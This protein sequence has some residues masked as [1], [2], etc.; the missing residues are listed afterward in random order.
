MLNKSPSPS[1]QTNS[2]PAVRRWR[3]GLYDV[4]M[5][6]LLPEFSCQWLEDEFD[7]IA[8]RS[9]DPFYIA[10]ETKSMLHEVYQYWKGKTTSELATSYM[11]PQTLLAI[12]HNMFTAG[13]YFYNGIGTMQ[14][15]SKSAITALQPRQ[16]R[17]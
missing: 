9:A 2:L 14:R 10:D 3:R 16:R 7:T 8:T 5:G 12:D 11:A 6:E 17:S 4:S 1:G 15:C 13:N